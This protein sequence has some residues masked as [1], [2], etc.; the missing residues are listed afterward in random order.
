MKPLIASA[1]SKVST[2]AA[3]MSYTASA[4]NKLITPSRSP[5]LMAS[6]PCRASLTRSGG[7]GLLGHR[8]LSI[9][10][11]CFRQASERAQGVAQR[12][13]L[14]RQA[15]VSADARSAIAMAREA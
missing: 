1:P 12:Y 3:D 2:P 8:A 13:R 7:R 15:G 6:Y 4:A 9:A 11:R 14:G 5:R 10:D